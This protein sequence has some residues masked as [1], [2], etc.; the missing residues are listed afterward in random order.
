MSKGDSRSLMKTSTATQASA[1]WRQPA[2]AE[3]SGA[4][5][6]TRAYQ[7]KALDGPTKAPFGLALS[8]PISTQKKYSAREIHLGGQ[9]ARDALTEIGEIL[10]S[11]RAVLAEEQRYQT[12]RSVPMRR[13]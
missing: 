5:P 7:G 6:A 12:W 13:K 9:L 11:N 4:F 8:P 10:Q 2:A 1:A 3:A